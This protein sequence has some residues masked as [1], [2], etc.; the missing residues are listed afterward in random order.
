MAGLAVVAVVTHSWWSVVAFLPVAFVLRRAGRP[1]RPPWSWGR[2]ARVLGIVAVVYAAVTGAAFAALQLHPLT[3]S[4]NMSCSGPAGPGILAP[5]DP[6]PGTGPLLYPSHGLGRAAAC[7]DVRNN[8]WWRTASVLGVASSALPAGT[9]WRVSLAVV[10]YDGSRMRLAPAPATP[11]RAGREQQLVFALH[12]AAC[13]P[14]AA[15]RTEVLRAIPLEVR[16]AGAIGTE[17]VALTRPV[18]TRCPG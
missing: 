18:A 3:A 15:G 14:G 16:V 9:P 13:G 10:R 12:L 4:P 17:S 7:V 6:R 1:K 8:A 5:I 2:R 11:I